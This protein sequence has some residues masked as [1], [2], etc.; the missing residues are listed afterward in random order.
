M[1]WSL[2]QRHGVQ[3]VSQFFFSFFFKNGLAGHCPPAFYLCRSAAGTI[4]GGESIPPAIECHAVI[5]TLAKSPREPWPFSFFFYLHSA[6]QTTNVCPAIF[7]PTATFPAVR[8]LLS[9]PITRTIDGPSVLCRAL[10]K[11]TKEKSVRP[12]CLS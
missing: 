11:I 12:K 6:G 7:S 1:C 9:R 8:P 4:S 10:E 5:E 2:H 3:L